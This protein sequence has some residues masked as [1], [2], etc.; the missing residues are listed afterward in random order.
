MNEWRLLV[1]GAG[2]VGC[3]GAMDL[4]RSAA[5]A[6]LAGVTVCDPAR[7][8][9]ASAVTCP[10]YAGYI[11][12][13]KCERLADLLREAAAAPVRALA[14]GVEDLPWAEVVP[15]EDAAR[16]IRTVALAG[17]DR[18]TSRLIVAEDVRRHAAA[19]GADIL[20]VQVGLDRDRAQV[21][22]LGSRWDDPC[23][24]C[25]LASLP[26]PEPCVAFGEGGRLVR[27]NLWREMRAAARLVRRIVAE[28]LGLAPAR[29]RWIN[30]KVSLT[31]RRPRGRRFAAFVRPCRRVPGCV[32]PHEPRT[33]LRSDAILERLAL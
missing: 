23:P 13:Y 32:G 26:G 7:V 30:M 29:R 25:G 4:A 28:E 31:A 1:L 22:V 6:R 9:A 18:W 3:A 2:T 21:G 20:H 8:R 15:A 24:A 19:T 27:G 12:M 5:G 11:G 14:R 16:G 10:P 33:P 17:L